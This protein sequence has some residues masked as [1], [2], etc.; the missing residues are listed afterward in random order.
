MQYNYYTS[1]YG[2][3]CKH[4]FA[5]K[6]KQIVQ[7]A[8]LLIDKVPKNAND[9]ADSDDVLKAFLTLCIEDL[10]IHKKMCHKIKVSHATQTL[11]GGISSYFVIGVGKCQMRFLQG[12]VLFRQYLPCL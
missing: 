4:S 11:R 1:I 6:S 5:L 7:L 10:L 2:L 12:F 3:G 8:C 9:P